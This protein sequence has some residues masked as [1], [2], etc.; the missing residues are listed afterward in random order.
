MTGF[1]GDQ[2]EATPVSV[3]EAT[4][5]RF[6]SAVELLVASSEGAE[7]K[8]AVEAAAGEPPALLA[9]VTRIAALASALGKSPEGGGKH[10][11]AVSRVTAVL[12]RAMAFVEEEFHALLQGPRV[13]TALVEHV[14]VVEVLRSSAPRHYTARAEGRCRR[15]RAGRASPAR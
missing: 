8:W 10:A 6:A 3:T 12:H 1:L 9:A 5:D 4:L 7:E 2:D 14:S 11:A 13:P 15:S